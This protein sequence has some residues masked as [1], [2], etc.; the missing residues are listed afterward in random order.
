MFIVITFIVAA[1]NVKRRTRNARPYGGKGRKCYISIALT[2]IP[3]GFLRGTAVPLK[4]PE[5]SGANDR[6][7][8]SSVSL[9]SI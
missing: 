2:A 6:V 9:V 1:V 3:R 5:G 8:A 4:R 7:V